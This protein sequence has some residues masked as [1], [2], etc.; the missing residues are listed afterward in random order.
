VTG[1]AAIAGPEASGSIAP[2]PVVTG[3]LATS[4]LVRHGAAA[5]RRVL[6]GVVIGSF[7]FC[8]FF[9]VVAEL[10]P[11]AGLPATYALAVV[12]ALVVH[13]AVRRAVRA[14]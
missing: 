7:G 1:F 4:A 11:R 10:L 8:G 6:R 13:T 12:A 9:L 2:L 5:A 14:P 3:V